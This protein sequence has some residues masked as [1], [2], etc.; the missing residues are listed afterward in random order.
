MAIAEIGLAARARGVSARLLSRSALETLAETPD[1]AAFARGLSRVGGAVEPAGEA[2]D[3][4]AI[5]LA[6]RRTAA[7]HLRTLLR[8]RRRPGALDVFLAAQDR[9]SLRALLRGALQSAP[10]AERLAGLIPTPLLPERVLLDLAHQP[11]PSA[12]V[13][14]LFLLGHPD[15]HRLSAPAAKTQPELFPIEAA[16]LEGFVARAGEVA[17]RDVTLARYLRDLV[18]IGNLQNALL[19]A[20]EPG[21]TPVE[22]AFVEGGAAM[23]R[24]GFASAAR[25]SSRTEALALLARALAATPLGAFTRAGI[26]AAGGI[27]RAWL[28]DTTVALARQARLDPLGS[29][30]L[31]CA[32]LRIETQARDLRALAWGAA[33]GVP[34]VVRRQH[35]V[36]P[37][38]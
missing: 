37:W 21:D 8:W 16:L 32:L 33:L 7:R 27:E 28:D 38:P 34:P 20:G 31:L 29:A 22:Q 9:R 25:A 3:L 11:S 14:R 4:A 13:G 23:T 35:L 18:D 15:A 6:A 10:A 12:I 36:T 1:L 17:R 2:P 5:E 19:L 24:D 26:D 30:P